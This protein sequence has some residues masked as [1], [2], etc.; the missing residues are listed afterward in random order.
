MDHASAACRRMIFF[1]KGKRI[2]FEI[3]NPRS[4]QIAVLRIDI[5]KSQL[6]SGAF[7]KL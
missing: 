5:S 3:K 1:E 6:L 4:N 7:S 2:I